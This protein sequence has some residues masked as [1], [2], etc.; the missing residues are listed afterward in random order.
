MHVRDMKT[1][2]SVSWYGVE[3]QQQIIYNIDYIMVNIVINC[4]RHE[5]ELSVSWYGVES[6]TYDIQY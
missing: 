5:T 4:A 1:E 3:P 2:L 6:P